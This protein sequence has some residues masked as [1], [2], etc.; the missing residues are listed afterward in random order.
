MP[1][2][3]NNPKL[4]GYIPADPKQPVPTLAATSRPDLPPAVDLSPMC[5]P[6]EDQGTVGSCTANA[7]AG[8][9][10][11]HQ[12]L[13]RQPLTDLSRLFIYYNARKLMGT[14]DQD[15]GASMPSVVAAYLAFGA[16]P[17]PVWPY[18]PSI[19]SHE[20]P[21]QAYAEAIHFSSLSYAS[22]NHGVDLKIALASGLPIIFGM[23][24][25]QHALMVIGRERGYVPAP[26]DGNWEPAS[27]GHAMLIVGYDDSKNAW[28][29]RNSWGPGWG[30]NGYVWIDYRVMDHYKQP[31]GFWTIGALDRAKYFKLAGASVEQSVEATVAK[32]PPSVQ[33]QIRA[34]K[35][36]LRNDLET[37]LDATRQ[38][39]RDRLRGPG[40]GG[41][42][43]RGPGAGGGYDRGPGAGGGYDRGPGAGGGYED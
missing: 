27:S 17:E 10:E 39:L 18:D 3:Q 25:P 42:Y 15:S 34:F 26:E 13:H 22:I 41:G 37:N 33:D 8:A 19:W 6:V 21:Q 1:I 36:H 43:N 9:L 29:V 24:V 5:S 23:S 7:V 35:S 16:C 30:I 38:G 11:Y 4:G 31:L 40:A 28:L 32:A 14:V 12:I 20:P 2:A